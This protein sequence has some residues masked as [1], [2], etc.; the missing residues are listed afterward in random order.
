MKIIPI[1]L[2]IFP[3]Y[4]IAQS[5]EDLVLDDSVRESDSSVITPPVF[6]VVGGIYGVTEHSAPSMSGEP[7]SAPPPINPLMFTPEEI[8]QLKAIQLKALQAKN[9]NLTAL[10]IRFLDGARNRLMDEMEL[11][12]RTIDLHARATFEGK[13]PSYY[14]DL[15]NAGDKDS[16]RIL[17]DA[18]VCGDRFEFWPNSNLCSRF[19]NPEIC[20]R[21]YDASLDT[22]EVLNSK[23]EAAK[24]TFSQLIAENNYLRSKLKK[25]K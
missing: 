23:Q 16:A 22:I 5:T 6:G 21:N 15:V 20:E 3:T 18:K 11:Y 12:V 8:A 10:D 7:L 9:P 14:V 17:H 1:L 13:P 25:R 24:Q 2:F 4:L 19:P